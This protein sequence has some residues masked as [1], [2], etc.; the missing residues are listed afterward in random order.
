MRHVLKNSSEVTHIWAQQSQDSGRCSNVF[1]EG[2]SIYSYGRHFEMGRFIMPEIVF[3]T[4]R[5]YS[6]TTAK[7]LQD[8]RQAV[9]HKT[10]FVVASFTDH[11]ANIDYFIGEYNNH[12]DK[13]AKAVKNGD[14]YLAQANGQAQI[15][16]EYISIF[17]GEISDEIIGKASEIT[18]RPIDTDL[19]AKVKEKIKRQ[20]AAE[21][22]KRK[23]DIEKWY[24]F[25]LNQTALSRLDRVFLRVNPTS[26]EVETSKGARVGIREA[27][28]LYSMIQAGKPIHGHKIGNYTC[29]SYINGILTIDCHN[30][31]RF[32]IDKIAPQLV[33]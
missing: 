7:H 32:E 22:A 23:E 17:F 9:R 27:H 19:I 16:R 2:K 14:M 1:F 20:K 13:A 26:L 28:C 5:S 21:I 30:I 10:V 12:L 15:I 3:L 29:V 33:A 4:N 8:V 11:D 24:S 18:D 25:R 6:V 31:D